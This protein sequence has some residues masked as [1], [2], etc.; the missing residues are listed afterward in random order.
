MIERSIIILY[1]TIFSVLCGIV[2]CV[3]LFKKCKDKWWLCYVYYAFLSSVAGGGLWMIMLCSL[4]LPAAELLIIESETS[5]TIYFVYG[6]QKKQFI[7]D[8]E[9]SNAY[10]LNKMN[11]SILIHTIPRKDNSQ[12]SQWVVI[13]PNQI[14]EVRDF[15]TFFFDKNAP[16]YSRPRKKGGDNP[17]SAV[18][19][20]N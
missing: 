19:Y 1:V 18:D 15:P 13:P 4:S 6:E 9:S 10:V 17:W 8:L 7:I 3:I 5:H 2:T 12:V 16:K 14:S 20:Y 11:K